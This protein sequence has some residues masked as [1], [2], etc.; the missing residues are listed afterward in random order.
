MKQNYGEEPQ[1]TWLEVL[2]NVPGGTCTI[3]FNEGIEEGQDE[4]GSVFYSAEHY[5]METAWREGLEASVKANREAWLA[6]AKAAGGGKPKTEA[7][8]LQEAISSLQEQN[9]ELNNAIDDLTVAI[10]EGGI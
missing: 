9:E 6:A 10:L 3:H 8:I 2:H 5:T 7:E 4:D 1:A